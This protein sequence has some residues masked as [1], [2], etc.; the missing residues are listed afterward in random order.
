MSI[1][2][3]IGQPLEN[4]HVEVSATYNGSGTKNFS[5]PEDKADEF[6]STYTKKFN[7]ASV[8]STL[9][10]CLLGGLGGLA[11][12]QLSKN[13]QSKALRWTAII[14]GGIAAYFVSMALLAK[15]IINLDKKLQAEFGAKEIKESTP[16]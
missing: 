13:S 4:K 2:M 14:G 7:K 3:Q 1:V 10:M 6:V 5:V 11:G 15:P 9:G 12:G 16:S 8:Y